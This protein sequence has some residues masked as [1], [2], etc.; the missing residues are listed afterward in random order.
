MFK[1][2]SRILEKGK[3]YYL[4]SPLWFRGVII[5]DELTQETEDTRMYKGIDVSVCYQKENLLPFFVEEIYID[6]EYDEPFDEEHNMHN[7]EFLESNKEHLNAR[8]DE[9][10]ADIKMGSKIDNYDFE[11]NIIQDGMFIEITDE[12]DIKIAKEQI[13]KYNNDVKY[14][15]EFENRL[16]NIMDTFEQ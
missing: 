10:D 5:E 3:Y 12:N 11:G 2:K 7:I 6:I 15:E 4:A 8:Y 16:C 14:K 9:V 13:H 1:T